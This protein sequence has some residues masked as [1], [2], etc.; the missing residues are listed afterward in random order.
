RM[1]FDWKSLVDVA[2]ELARMTATAANAEAYQRS[3]VNR[4]YFG[5]FG[6]AFDYA[7]RF[8]DY[9]AKENPEEHGRLREHLRKKRRKNAAERL[10]Q[11]RQLRNDA[12]YLNDLPW[13][14]IDATVNAALRI[15]NEVLAI[16]PPP[17]AAAR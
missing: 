2:G 11:L 9:D 10:N 15:A 7:T 5:A 3:A 8:L 6:Y 13:A 4:A 1:A 16:L 14:D 12:D 17:S